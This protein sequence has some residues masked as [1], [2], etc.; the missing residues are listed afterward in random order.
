MTVKSQSFATTRACARL[1]TARRIG[2]CKLIVDRKSHLILGAHVVGQR[3]VEIVQLVAVG[4][5][6]GLHVEQLAA[7]DLAYPTYVQ[8]IG[9][10]AYRA[11]LAL[12]I[13][14]KEVG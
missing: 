12:K 1:S 11:C 14:L 3:A 5:A 8:I 10:A 13:E 6:T 2:F 7:V 9:E 4:M